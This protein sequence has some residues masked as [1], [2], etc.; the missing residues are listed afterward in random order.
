MHVLRHAGLLVI[1]ACCEILGCYLSFL[2]LRRDGAPWLLG[3]AAA[4]LAAFAYLLTLHPIAP[5]RTYAAYGG[6][7]VATAVFWL[8]LV[9]GQRPDRWDLIGAGVS[10]VG[11]G[12]ILF[13][14]RGE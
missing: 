13:G 11:M 3:P 9:D 14:P 5:G 12:L 2:W 10:L 7:Y 6:A 1:T 4:S 8:W